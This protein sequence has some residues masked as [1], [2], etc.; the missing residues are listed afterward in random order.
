MPSIQNIYTITHS[1]I[2]RRPLALKQ[3]SDACCALPFLGPVVPVNSCLLQ[4]LLFRETNMNLPS[5]IC[6]RAAFSLRTFSWS[7][8]WCLGGVK[9]RE[10]FK[11][12]INP[13][14]LTTALEHPVLSEWCRANLDVGPRKWNKE[15]Q[16]ALPSAPKWTIYSNFI[17]TYIHVHHIVTSYLVRC[18]LSSEQ[19]LM[20]LM[21]FILSNGV[22]RTLC[23]PY[24]CL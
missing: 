19:I 14:K 24:S 15:Y 3:M 8:P 10:G 4:A 7:V 2:L 6:P 21:K 17:I 12:L 16:P 13:S 18:S 23:W 9:N 5:S 22:D 20:V 1:D 11:W